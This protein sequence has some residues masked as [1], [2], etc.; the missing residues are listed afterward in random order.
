M[1]NAL[2]RSVARNFTALP[3]E[4][5]RWSYWSQLPGDKA[6]T[7]VKEKVFPFLKKLGSKTGSFGEHMATAEF[8]INK[9][10]LL[11][12]ACKAID[13]MQISAQNQDVQGD[14]YEYLSQSPQHRGHQRPI[15]HAAP[16]H[17]HDGANDRSSSRAS[18]SSTPP[19]ALAAF[20]STHGNI[21]LRP[22]LINATSPM[23]MR[24]G[25]TA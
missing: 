4:E 21:F 9:P 23:T 10:S 16:H 12:E 3:D 13:E 25:R 14:L 6:V 20:S 15:P 2:Q 8:K 17:P 22:T 19:P 11:I 24:A 7:I 18:A 1:P 5:L